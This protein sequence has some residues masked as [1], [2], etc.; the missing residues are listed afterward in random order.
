MGIALRLLSALFV[1]LA[2]QTAW[3]GNTG[4]ITGTVSDAKTKEPL[5]G[6]NVLIIGTRQGATSDT[7]GEFFIANVPAG[8]YTLQFKQVGY[9]G[10]QMTDVRVRP[11]ATT[12]VHLAME[13]T[14][15]D[16]GQEVVVTAERP[17][18]QKDNTATRVYVESADI[19][20]LPAANVTDVLNTLPSVNND[21]GV[22]SV[23]GGGLNEVS[24]L[25]DGARARNPNDQTPYT[26]INLS[27]IQQMEVITGS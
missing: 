27:S 19:Q 12:E 16:I 4:K 1:F 22:M 24:F 25:I 8:T 14:V 9:K 10:M 3:A 23:R 7:R 21:N 15:V 20:S 26:S 11:D 17:L 5:V 18:V 2:V 13:E 6:V